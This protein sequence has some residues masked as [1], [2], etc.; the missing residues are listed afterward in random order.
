MA[1]KKNEFWAGYSNNEIYETE[2]QQY[3]YDNIALMPS[4]YKK[5]K[6]AKERFEDVRLVKVIEADLWK[7]DCFGKGC[8]NE[9]C[10]F[11]DECHDLHIKL[12]IENLKKDSKVKPKKKGKKCQ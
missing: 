2:E 3:G 7:P 6:D 9:N 8:N 1:K 4:I 10:P 5:K 12:Y 11:A